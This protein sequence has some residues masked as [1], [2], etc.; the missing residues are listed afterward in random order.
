MEGGYTINSWISPLD[1]ML[2]ACRVVDRL[3]LELEIRTGPRAG[4]YPTNGLKMRD[5]VR[6]VAAEVDRA[7]VAAGV[8][9]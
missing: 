1:V 5:C 7:A 2:Y 8:S 9:I 4:G 3:L 6:D